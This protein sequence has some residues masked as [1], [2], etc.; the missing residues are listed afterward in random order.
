[1]AGCSTSETMFPTTGSLRL[2]L[3]DNDLAFQ[4]APQSSQAMRWVIQSA[5]AD[6]SGVPAPFSFLGFA[7]C[8]YIDHVFVRGDVASECAGS[9]LV[10]GIDAV[11]TVTVH[12]T[13]TRIELRRA[14]S[15]DLPDTGDYDGDGVLNASDNCRLIQN[16]PDPTS[17]V[18]LDVNGDGI[19]DACSLPDQF[20]SPTIPDQDRDGVLDGLDNCL[21]VPNDID[22]VT[23]VQPD[24]DGDSIGDACQQIVPV[25]MPGGT[26]SLDCPMDITPTASGL[27]VVEVKFDH[28]T[29]LTCSPAFWSC[30]LDP[31]KVTV[32]M[33]G[34][35]STTSCTV[36]N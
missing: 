2:G 21:L 13:V 5:T 7:P 22:P 19:G 14:M 4:S 36:V 35:D 31:T 17:G 16:P 9:G 34:I 10:L 29:T 20:A 15:P 23:L 24:S 27:S 6:V 1:M 12:L 33:T 11:R 25:T 30:T 26:V 32:G 8:T 3:R 18:Q 28:N